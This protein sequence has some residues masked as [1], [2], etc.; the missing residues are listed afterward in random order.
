[1]KKFMKV[2]VILL[3]T[4]ALRTFS[5]EQPQKDEPSGPKENVG[6]LEEIDKKVEALF[7][8]IETENVDLVRS[9]LGFGI[10]P[11]VRQ[12]NI[13]ALQKAQQ[14]GNS[15]IIQLLS[16]ADKSEKLTIESPGRYFMDSAEDIQ[17]APQ[18]EVR[19]IR[20]PTPPVLLDLVDGVIQMNDGEARRNED[21]HD[22]ERPARF[23]SP[24]LRRQG[25]DT[26][27]IIYGFN[28]D[29]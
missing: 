19:P 26:G 17:F 22:E 1:M 9:A 27:A 21:R 13:T 20:I 5:M 29:N 28:L 4:V 2:I 7:L 12:G 25:R 16:N 10:S 15:E 3:L 6:F 11:F 18:P 8:G 24:Y 23:V 14:K